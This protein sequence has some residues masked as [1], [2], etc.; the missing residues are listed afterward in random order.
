M[1][2]LISPK[3]QFEEAVAEGDYFR[4][5]GV[6]PSAR[7]L[8]IDVAAAR[9]AEQ[10]P[11]LAQRIS[12]VAHVLIAQ[13]KRTVYEALQTLRDGVVESL[14]RQYGS[15]F[16]EQIPDLRRQIWKEC[17]KLMRFD[18]GCS[19]LLVGPQG[20]ASLAEVGVQWIVETVVFQ[21]VNLVV[22][23]L[24]SEKAIGVAVRYVWYAECPRCG[25]KQPVLCRLKE[26]ISP[27]EQKPSLLPAEVDFD[28]SR[29]TL[30]WNKCTYCSE[31][32]GPPVDWDDIYRFP[33][34]PSADAGQLLRGRGQRT[35]KSLF[36]FNERYP[37]HPRPHP[38]LHIFYQAQEQGKDLSFQ[39][40]IGSEKSSIYANTPYEPSGP[41]STPSASDAAAPSPLGRGGKWSSRKKSLEEWLIMELPPGV[42]HGLVLLAV[43]LI[44]LLVRN[45]K[46]QVPPPPESPNRVPWWNEIQPPRAEERWNIPRREPLDEI[47]R[48]EATQAGKKA[49]EFVS[50]RAR[51]PLNFLQEVASNKNKKALEFYHEGQYREALEEYLGILAILREPLEST[52]RLLNN[53]IWI[54]CA[55][56]WSGLGDCFYKIGLIDE[57]RGAYESALAMYKK[58]LLRPKEESPNIAALH[59][60][61]GH[62]FWDSDDRSQAQKHFQAAIQTYRQVEKLDSVDKLR[63]AE[64]HCRL[65]ENFQQE[66]QLKPAVQHY[67]RA[68]TYWSQLYQSGALPPYYQHRLAAAHH[69]LALLLA[70][71]A[72]FPEA[73]GHC[74][75]A[76]RLLEEHLQ[77]E[78]D[79]DT[80]KHLLEEAR[81]QASALLEYTYPTQSVSLQPKALEN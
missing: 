19:T 28:E 64:S 43:F 57:A 29:Y 33:I 75:A 14:Q 2:Q 8:D 34:F 55:H 71:T 72:N 74:Q 22:S 68:I 59:H 11:Q 4:A 44:L 48:K 3:Y 42:A 49:Q 15:E 66:E 1:I 52:H 61:L 40:S 23:I 17:C 53:R 21:T 46:Q 69:E 26:R 47:P 20:A 24:P 9:L 38:A 18:L 13:D 30:D 51:L 39:E 35:G 7:K 62:I 63:C 76:I 16:L 37:P 79:C 6:M 60:A 32:L 80:A 25:A 58:A 27:A 50:L 77:Q 67:S 10:I 45:P 5:L 36:A 41:R 73:Y 12:A 70:Q 56:A 81:Q 78:W 54:C 65:A 31:T